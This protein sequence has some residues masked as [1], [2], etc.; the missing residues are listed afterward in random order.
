M[1]WEAGGGE[2]GGRGESRCGGGMGIGE[3]GECGT[4]EGEFHGAVCVLDLS[5]S[6][7]T[8]REVENNGNE[9]G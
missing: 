2:S 3:D 1:S 6:T 5:Y 9:A 4:E 8:Q 7:S